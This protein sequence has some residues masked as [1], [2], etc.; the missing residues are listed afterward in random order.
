MLLS[1]YFTR[2]KILSKIR[3]PLQKLDISANQV[4][5]YKFLA[6]C[7]SFHLYQR[8]SESGVHAKT[9]FISS[10]FMLLA[11]YQ[12][13]ETSGNI[14]QPRKNSKQSNKSWLCSSI[15]YYCARSK[16]LWK[17]RRLPQFIAN[18][19]TGDFVFFLWL[20]FPSEFR[21]LFFFFQKEMEVSSKRS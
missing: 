13:G 9:P 12:S 2:V 21:D 5:C 11:R 20:I 4:I 3:Y 17:L 1:V 6:S 16:A 8:S 10:S 14:E 7:Y 19:F 15:V 18:L